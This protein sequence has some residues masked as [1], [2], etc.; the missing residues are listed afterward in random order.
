MLEKRFFF[1]QIQ[2][3]VHLTRTI[4]ICNINTPML[5]LTIAGSFKTQALE[6]FT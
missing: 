2:K 4:V 3:R 1:P 6:A 5:N